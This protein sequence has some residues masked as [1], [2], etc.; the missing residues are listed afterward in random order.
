M[1]STQEKARPAV[2][3][4]TNIGKC[5]CDEKMRTECDAELMF[6]VGGVGNCCRQAKEDLAELFVRRHAPHQSWLS[7]HAGPGKVRKGKREFRG[8]Q[9]SNAASKIRILKITIMTLMTMMYRDF[10]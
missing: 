10:D 3:G 2:A 9:Y 5:E 8:L 6:H 4:Q 1:A 7:A